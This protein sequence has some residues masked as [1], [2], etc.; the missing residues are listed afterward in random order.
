MKLVTNDIDVAAIDQQ[1]KHILLRIFFFLSI[2]VHLLLA[3]FFIYLRFY[4]LLIVGA[5]NCTIFIFGLFLIK[6]ERYLLSMQLGVMAIVIGSAIATYYLGWESHFNLY[7]I[8]AAIVVINAF[9]LSLRWK[10]VEISSLLTLYVFMLVYTNGGFRAYS[11]DPEFL[12]FFSIFNLFAFI[13]AIFFMQFYYHRENETLKTGLEEIS[14]IDMLTGA[15]NRRF[16]NKYLDIEIRRLTS[17]IKYQQREIDFS[18]AMIDVDDFK[19]INDIYGH[20]A[21]D[22]VLKNVA[23]IIKRVLFE[24]DILCR[25]GGDEFVVLFTSTSK[26]GAIIAIEKILDRVG[27]LEFE[28]GEDTHQAHITVSVGFASTDEESDIYKLIDLADKRL[29][30]AKESGKNRAVSV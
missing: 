30:A 20:L 14:E 5:V 29:Y 27:G 16:F 19:R 21:G 26:S 3:V 13:A 15:Y 24:R 1:R 23:S 10:L 28:L 18:I 9:T 8:A 22:T 4:E 12:N 11:I 7:I 25:Y 17:Q 2:S 6:K